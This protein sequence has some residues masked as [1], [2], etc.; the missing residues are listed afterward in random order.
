MTK[1]KTLLSLLLTLGLLAVCALLPGIVAAVQDHA[2]EN[3][4]GYSSIRSVSLELSEEREVQQILGRLALIRDGSFYNVAAANASMTQEE[5]QE[6]VKYGLAPYYD[7]ELLPDYWTDTSVKAAPYFV[8]D[9]ETYCILWVVSV[10]WGGGV[11][12]ASEI[13]YSLDLYV[14]DETGKI[15]Y[16]HYH[17]A[18][19][20][21]AYAEIFADAY[22]ESLGMP[23]ILKDPAADGIEEVLHD[24]LEQGADSDV[25]VRYILIHEQY[26]E[27]ILE[28][29]TYDQGFYLNIV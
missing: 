10:A 4:A 1:L 16:V 18:E 13:Q 22:F 28:F 3:N 2:A 17:G 20:L 11:V 29:M 7:L 21:E 25:G 9:D 12:N 5:V 26:D 27:L 23:D 24:A 15:L 19:P 14:D 8:Y 6:A